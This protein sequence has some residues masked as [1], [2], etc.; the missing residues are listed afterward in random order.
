MGWGG[1]YLVVCH[2]VLK[3]SVTTFYVQQESWENYKNTM[4]TERWNLMSILVLV[5]WCKV[6]KDSRGSSSR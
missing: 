4:G 2:V 1:T 3:I 5:E 6:K